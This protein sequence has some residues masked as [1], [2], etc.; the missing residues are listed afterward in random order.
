[1]EP[2]PDFMQVIAFL[3]RIHAYVPGWEIPKLSHDSCA[4][5]YGFITDYFCEIMHEMRCVELLSAVRSRFDLIDT[6]NTGQGISG[7]DQRAVM[8]T[9]SRLRRLRCR[10]QRGDIA[11]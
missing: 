1:L 7:R 11:N 4:K 6:A 3:D 10:Y 8:K 2:L 9:V 5:D